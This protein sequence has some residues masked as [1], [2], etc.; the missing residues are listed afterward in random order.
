MPFKVSQMENEKNQPRVI[1]SLTHTN[2]YALLMATF[3]AVFI[4][5]STACLQLI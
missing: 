1:I 2:K 3:D 4:Y 5:S